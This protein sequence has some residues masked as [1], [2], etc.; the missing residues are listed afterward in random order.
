MVYQ[1][2]NKTETQA[3]IANVL[4]MLLKVP[5][6]NIHPYTHLMDDLN[7][8]DIDRLLLIVELERMFNVFLSTEE[9]EAIETVD[10]ASTLMVKYA[11]AA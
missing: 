7:L 3:Q 1:I 6:S 10:D 4:S 2:E 5:A 11:A 8:D 9:V